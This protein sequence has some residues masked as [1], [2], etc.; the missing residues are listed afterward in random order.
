MAAAAAATT[1][2][3]SEG[4]HLGGLAPGSPFGGEKNCAT[5]NVKK[6]LCENLNTFENVHVKCMP[7]S[8]LL[9]F[10]NKPLSE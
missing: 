9:R 6:K 8:P 10:L 1:T 2:T 5:I 7:G 4:A 3:V